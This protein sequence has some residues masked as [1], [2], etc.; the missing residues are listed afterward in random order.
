MVRFPILALEFFICPFAL[1]LGITS[2]LFY[3]LLTKDFIWLIFL[4]TIIA[5]MFVVI[6][7]ARKRSLKDM[8][9]MIFGVFIFQTAIAHAVL[10]TLFGI[11]KPDWKKIEGQRPTSALTSLE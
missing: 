6:R 4:I 8:L 9:Y 11:S 10:D 5:L 1:F 7:P 3:S 2:L